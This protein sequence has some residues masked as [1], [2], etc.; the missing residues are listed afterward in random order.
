M[1]CKKHQPDHKLAQS[2]T[3]VKATGEKS[4]KDVIV[5]VGI[6]QCTPEASVGKVVAKD[7]DMA[8]SVHSDRPESTSLQRRRKRLRAKAK[9]RLKAKAAETSQ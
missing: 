2:S 7:V 1:P 5:Q 4:V 6:V 3:M 9:A 8:E